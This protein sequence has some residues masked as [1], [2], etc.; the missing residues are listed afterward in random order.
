M[1]KEVQYE[2]G[3]IFY[4]YSRMRPGNLTS[5]WINP[6]LNH[7]GSLPLQEQEPHDV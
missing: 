2:Y 3:F 5:I 6:V 4:S 1:A 7:A